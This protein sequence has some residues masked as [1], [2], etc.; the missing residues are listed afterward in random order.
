MG[1]ISESNG[2]SF[3]DIFLGLRPV[4]E[5]FG[6][7]EDE[8]TCLLTR[9]G[10]VGDD[11]TESGSVKINKGRGFREEV[12]EAPFDGDSRGASVAELPAQ[13]TVLF[14]M[15]ISRTSLWPIL[16]EYFGRFSEKEFCEEFDRSAVG[17]K[18]WFVYGDFG[19]AT[20]EECKFV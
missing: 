9:I 5:G 4:G 11:G 13:L 3:H 15:G 14:L 8:D 19:G 6:T 17:A 20:E 1:I 10:V 2:S 12:E 18:I 7:S 16:G